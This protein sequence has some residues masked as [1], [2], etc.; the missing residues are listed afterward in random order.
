MF[1]TVLLVSVTSVSLNQS[2]LSNKLCNTLQHSAGVH[3]YKQ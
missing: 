2:G 3:L 1:S